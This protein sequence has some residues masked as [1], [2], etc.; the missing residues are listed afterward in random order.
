MN[1][2]SLIEVTVGK[3][4]AIYTSDEQNCDHYLEQA[5]EREFRSNPEFSDVQIEISYNYS[6]EYATVIAYND[7]GDIISERDDY[8]YDYAVMYA[9]DNSP[10]IQK[11]SVF[12]TNDTDE[13]RNFSVAAIDEPYIYDVPDP[14]QTGHGQEYYVLCERLDDLT[15]LAEGFSCRIEI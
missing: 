10:A 7:N 6:S 1:K 13:L 14:Q 4:P 15:R 5:I 2:V 8:D 12:W 11:I 3:L 9:I